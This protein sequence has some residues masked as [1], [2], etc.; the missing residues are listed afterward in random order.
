MTD[1]TVVTPSYA[2]DFE[3]FRDLHASV[4][5]HTAADVVHHVIVPAADRA[6][7]GEF[8]GAR[9]Q[10]HTVGEF[11]PAGLHRVPGANVWINRRRPWP[12]VRGW[13]VQQL[14]KLAATARIDAGVLLTADSDVLFVREVTA[15]TFRAPDGGVRLYRAPGAV[16]G[17]L[18]RHVL[19]HRVARELLGLPADGVTPPLPD[20]V[21]PLMSWDPRLVRDMLARVEQVAGRPWTDAIGGRLH[22][23]EG[24]LYGVHADE[25]AGA[26]RAG[27]ASAASL[28][29]CHWDEVPLD[30][31]A[32]AAFVRA[33]DPGDV[34]VMISAK[35]RTPLDVRRAA[36][37]VVDA[38]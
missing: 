14:V 11:L 23:S 16:D 37:T 3:L 26:E 18:P 12:P 24:I 28:C 36:W 15:A 19:W 6:L 35:S 27:H 4:L 33:R 25:F 32:A 1:L 30:E 29:H 20:Y 9:C 5:R 8:A 10:V 2:P 17:S 31:E 21:S 38:S 13:I 22:F 7:F 34:A